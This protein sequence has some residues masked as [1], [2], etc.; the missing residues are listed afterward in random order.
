MRAFRQVLGKPDPQDR[1]WLLA[2]LVLALLWPAVLAPAH[3]HPGSTSAA[4]LTFLPQGP[5][6]SAARVPHDGDVCPVCRELCHAA[7]YLAPAAGM[8]LAAALIHAVRPLALASDLGLLRP[9]SAWRSRAPP[10]PGLR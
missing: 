1:L 3:H 2:A 7:A 4:R 9:R 10:I 5:D 6:R 8:A